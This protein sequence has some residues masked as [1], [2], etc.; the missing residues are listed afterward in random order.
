MHI[1]LVSPLFF[2]PF[3]VTVNRSLISFLFSIYLSHHHFRF[4]SL[5]SVI[6]T[7]CEACS[8]MPDAGTRQVCAYALGRASELYPQGF[9]PYGLSVLQALGGCIAIGEGPGEARGE[10]TDNAVASVGLILERIVGGSGS[11]G[12]PSGI[13]FEFMWGQWLDYLPLK[14]DLVHPYFVPFYPHLFPFYYDHH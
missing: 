1:V 14:H 12:V 4:I 6:P 7:L 9:G 3:F 13:N 10:C 5:S 8:S 11:N 2:S